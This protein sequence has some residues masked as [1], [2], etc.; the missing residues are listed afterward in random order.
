MRYIVALLAL[1][2]LLG[3]AAGQTIFTGEGYSTSQLS[4]FNG[5][6]QQ[7][8][9][10]NVLKYWETYVEGDANMTAARGFTTNMDIWLNTFPDKFDKPIQI[11]SS[12]F[13]TNAP[14]MTGM[15]PTEM[16]SMNLKKVVT[17]NFEPSMGWKY[18]PADTTFSFTKATGT[19]AKD[20]K[21]QI[22]SQGIIS[23]F[24]I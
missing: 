9:Q 21:G 19:P 16:N 13:N 15:T 24:A 3:I 2:S 5:P 8:F 22:I 12:T 4:F 18:T 23:L 17:F 1:F 11:K 10:P 6:N 7:S 14:G 20:A